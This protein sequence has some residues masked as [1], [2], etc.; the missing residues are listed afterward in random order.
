LAFLSLAL[1]CAPIIL[2]LKGPQIRA[3]SP[4]IQEARYEHDVKDSVGEA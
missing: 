2:L 4:F 3:K 1:A